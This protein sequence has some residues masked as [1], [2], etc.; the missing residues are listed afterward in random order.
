MKQ[1][2]CEN[3]EYCDESP[4]KCPIAL[5]NKSYADFNKAKADKRMRMYKI[6]MLVLWILVGLWFLISPLPI[7]KFEFGCCWIALL[8]FILLS[9]IERKTIK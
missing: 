4:E 8:C 3:W 7:A 1:Y 2:C 9:L 6:I 5:R